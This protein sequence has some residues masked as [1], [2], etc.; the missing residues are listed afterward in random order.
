M[1]LPTETMK[2]PTALN[3]SSDD[4]QLE[5]PDEGK[6]SRQCLTTIQR[7]IA[8]KRSH[9]LNK[10]CSFAEGLTMVGIKVYNYNST[11]KNK[12]DNNMATKIKV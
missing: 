4:L 9:L 8:E 2:P 11:I 1:H 6:K 5:L 10:N 3:I 12:D 7:A